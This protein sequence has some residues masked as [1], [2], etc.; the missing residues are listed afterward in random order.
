[1]PQRDQLR[2]ELARWS[3]LATFRYQFSVVARRAAPVPT[4][5]KCIVRKGRGKRAWRRYVRRN[6][7]R[8]RRQPGL[9]AVM[10]ARERRA[11]D[12][13]GLTADFRQGGASSLAALYLHFKRTGQLAVFR[14]MYP[15]P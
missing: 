1:V 8:P 2:T 5:G 14:A 11:E 12:R 15:E 13:D 4:Q 7:M 3:L 9:A 10:A 6:T